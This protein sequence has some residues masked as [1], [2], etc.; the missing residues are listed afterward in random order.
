MIFNLI[1][2]AKELFY[3][4]GKNVET[5]LDELNESLANLRN[6]RVS[7][8]LD[9]N[10]NPFPPNAFLDS[11]L[12][13][14][15]AHGSLIGLNI[16]KYIPILTMRWYET[17]EVIRTVQ[18]AFDGITTHTRYSV[19]ATEW[20]AWKSGATNSDLNNALAVPDYSNAVSP[21]TS[22]ITSGS[23]S[24]TAPS[25]GNLH[26]DFS[27]VAKGASAASINGITVFYEQS[28]SVAYRA[29]RIIPM[30]KGDTFTISDCSKCNIVS[31]TKFV[32]FT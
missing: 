21:T 16:G 24:Y 2:K 14:G 18:I 31:N 32:P 11:A 29:V 6:I 8:V 30:R 17:S 27:I 5:A 7:D 22:N 19:S 23:W 20:G 15:Y 12:S 28:E 9:A 25:N 1:T 4:N 13:L 26:L 10:S 3:K